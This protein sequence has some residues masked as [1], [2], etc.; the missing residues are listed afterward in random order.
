VRSRIVY[1]NIRQWAENCEVYIGCGE[2]AGV[3]GAMLGEEI[4]FCTMK[5]IPNCSEGLLHF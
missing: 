1:G 5:I 2:C 4:L 3:K